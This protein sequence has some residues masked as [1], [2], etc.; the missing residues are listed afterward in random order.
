MP[1]ISFRVGSLPHAAAN[2]PLLMPFKL[3]TAESL[4]SD[5][6]VDDVRD[7]REEFVFEVSRAV[8]ESTVG[9]GIFHFY[10]GDEYKTLSAGDRLTLISEG[11][12]SSYEILGYEHGFDKGTGDSPDPIYT[13]EL[14]RLMHHPEY[15]EWARKIYSDGN[16]K[17]TL[18]VKIS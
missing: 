11:D 10:Y 7:L 14:F 16:G 2:P 17:R 4:A 18:S 5:I 1:I 6:R 12:T 3:L 13:D 9:G 8:L 15:A